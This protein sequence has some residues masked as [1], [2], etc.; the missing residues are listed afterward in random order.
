MT[1]KVIKGEKQNGN[2]LR[3]QNLVEESLCITMYSNLL[4]NH[5]GEKHRSHCA[6]FRSRFEKGGCCEGS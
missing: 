1:P 4:G 6:S 5:V 3:Y 2:P